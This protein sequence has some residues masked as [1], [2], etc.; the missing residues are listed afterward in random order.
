MVM[1]ADTWTMNAHGTAESASS[2]DTDPVAASASSPQKT[3]IWTVPFVTGL[4]L[5]P[6]QIS[7]Y[8]R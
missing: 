2:P 4:E 3:L 8:C 1:A 7:G 5:M 6:A